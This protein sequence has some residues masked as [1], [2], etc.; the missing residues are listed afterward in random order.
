MLYYILKPLVQTW[1]KIFFRKIYFTNAHILPRDKPLIFAVNHP[2]AFLDPMVVCVFIPHT[3]HF[4]LRGDMFASA[5]IRWVLKQIKTIPIFRARDGFRSLKNNQATFERCFQL[6]YERKHILIL[7]EGQT[8]HEKRMRPIQ[9]GTARM[10]FGAYDKYGVDDIEVVPVG[11]NY[12]DSHR[13]RSEIMIDIGTPIPLQN[14]LP[15]YKE[16]P[17]EAM[18]A[19][20]D[21]ISK[22]MKSR[23]VHIE[24]KKDDQFVES[25]LTLH[26]NFKQESILPAIAR[27]H[28]W[29]W[30]EK[31]IADKINKMSAGEKQTLR[32]QTNSYF[33]RLK[34]YNIPDVA[35][36]KPRYYN[37]INTL[38]IILGFVPFLLG[39]I[40]NYLPIFL[41]RTVANAVVKK[42][43][44]HSSV[45]FAVGLFAYLFYYFLLLVA[46]IIWGNVWAIV[47][48]LA[49]PVL[50]YA[51]LLYREI[52]KK[53]RGARRFAQLDASV[54]D[55]LRRVR[56]NLT[57]LIPAEMAERA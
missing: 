12:T 7:A 29:L 36:A 51:A 45:R 48:V 33:E 6:L 50:G 17:R 14:Y 52:Y 35:V 30:G 21:D 8:R 42:I 15:L 38:V 20:T 9:K 41:A 39:F 22:A 10:A 57:A 1:F 28:N 23:I 16:N 13:F 31:S 37:W 44:F 55:E 4:I 47:A 18:A 54:R 19:L 25:L 5:F 40:L 2:T 11:V 53:W 34:Q 32:S 26:R 49:V 43:E 27:G 56:S 46:A 3:L 24:H